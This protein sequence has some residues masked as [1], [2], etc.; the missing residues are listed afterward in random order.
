MDFK[1]GEKEFAD[2]DIAALTKETNVVYDVK[3]FLK[4]KVD[5]RL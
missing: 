5:G 2:F 4:G 3:G 1:R